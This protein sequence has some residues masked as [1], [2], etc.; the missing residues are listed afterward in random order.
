MPY[1]YDR[2]TKDW[3]PDP[4]PG[5]RARKGD[6]TTA[7]DGVKRIGASVS[8]HRQSVLS[9]SYPDGGLNYR[10]IAEAAGIYPTTCSRVITTL[11]R[12]GSLRLI[13]TQGRCG[14]YVKAA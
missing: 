2:I 13:G 14:L 4:Q 3:A 9:L 6:P 10:E 11:V 8:Q 12:E 5:F 1:D 7:H